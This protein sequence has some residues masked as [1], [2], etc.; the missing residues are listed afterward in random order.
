MEQSH[1]QVF[2]HPRVQSSK[3]LSRGSK[4]CLQGQTN[5]QK[6]SRTVRLGNSSMGWGEG[7]GGAGGGEERRLQW[8]GE[9]L[10]SR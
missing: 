1:Y 5:N 8:R 2:K 3:E 6:A 10:R 7:G 4:Q 9:Q